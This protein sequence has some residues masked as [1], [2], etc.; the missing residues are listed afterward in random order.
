MG[1]LIKKWKQVYWPA[2][3]E[4]S[5][6]ARGGQG[7]SQIV[8]VSDMQ[9][10]FIILFMGKFPFCNA[11]WQE[12]RKLLRISCP[13]ITTSLPRS[14]TQSTHQKAINNFHQKSAPFEKKILQEPI[15]GF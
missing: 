13:T 8:S 14:A 9:G 5:S 6:T 1:G 10:S 2:E 15:Q 7:T 12:K 11:E 4:C 3:D